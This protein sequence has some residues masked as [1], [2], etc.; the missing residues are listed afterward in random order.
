MFNITRP[1]AGHVSRSMMCFKHARLATIPV[2]IVDDATAC[3]VCRF[4]GKTITLEPVPVRYPSN[5]GT[6]RP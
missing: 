3:D 4:V 1:Y 5:V 6:V 2:F